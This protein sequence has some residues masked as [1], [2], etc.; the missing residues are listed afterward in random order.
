MTTMLLV[1]I[2]KVYSDWCPNLQPTEVKDLHR[3]GILVSVDTSLVKNFT[4]MHTPPQ[5]AEN[6]SNFI[7][8]VTKGGWTIF[9][10]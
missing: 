1:K 5:E 2:F 9:K 3:A 4:Q 6:S 8:N 7:G 10:K